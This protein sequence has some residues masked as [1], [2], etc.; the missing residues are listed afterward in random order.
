VHAGA[1]GVGTAAI[2]IAKAIGARIA[3]TCSVGKVQACCDLG[4]D[5]VVERSPHDWLGELQSEVPQGFDVVLDVI[6][7][8]EVDRNLKVV[9]T[10]GTIVQVG[11]M[12]GGSTQV[13]VGLLLMKRAH[14]IGTTLRA[15]PL[16]EKATVT[17]KFAAEMLPLFTSG[18]L[19][20]IIDSRYPFDRIA[21]AHIAMGA[22]ANTGKIMIDISSAGD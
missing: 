12:S 9:A 3:V 6:G 19:K 13:N 11:L 4:A 17:R 16:E 7:G 1:S 8:E 2:Q 14:W 5:L 10:K 22:N 21:D 20:P 15:R 18:Q